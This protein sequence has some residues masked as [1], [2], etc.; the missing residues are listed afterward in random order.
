MTLLPITSRRD[1][2]HSEAR[3]AGEIPGPK[4]RMGLQ[5]TQA[6]NLTRPQALRDNLSRRWWNLRRT[7]SY[8]GE[9]GVHVWED[10]EE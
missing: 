7:A 3:Q 9:M 10:D 4:P 1:V 2:L 8:V 6:K 5:L